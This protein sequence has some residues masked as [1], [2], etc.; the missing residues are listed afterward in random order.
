MNKDMNFKYLNGLIALLVFIV[1]FSCEKDMGGGIQTSKEKY[2]RENI[3]VENVNEKYTLGDTIWFSA[4]IS[5]KLTDTETGEAI[6]LENQ[7]YIL[8]G[9]INLLKRRYDSLFFI[10]DNFDLVSD[11]G[12]VQLINV[13]N[14]EPE[15]Y[16]FDMRFGKPLPTNEVRFGLVLNYQG[17]FAIE[18]E[19]LVYFGSERID[20]DNYSLDNEKGYIDLSFSNNSINDSLFYALHKEYIAYYQNYYNGSAITSNKFYFFEVGDE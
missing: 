17:I 11:L 9:V 13:F 8:N 1:L 16:T 19:S 14:Y 4:T 10:N 12:E 15:S 20:Y 3:D 2:F 6:S 7:T 5:N 18:F